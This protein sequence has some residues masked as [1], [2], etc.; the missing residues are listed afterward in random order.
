MALTAG[1]TCYCGTSIPNDSDQVSESKC[2][3]PCWGWGNQTCG[4]DNV[5]GVWADGLSLFT[6]TTAINT[7]TSASQTNNAA[8]TTTSSP[9]V[10]TEANHTVV[11]TATGQTT[12]TGSS[13]SGGGGG[14]SNTAGIAAGV[15][16][17]VV[18]LAAI[19]G[20]SL[21]FIRRQKRRAVEESYR[22]NAAIN[23]FVG[24][25]TKPAAAPMS[26]SRWDGDFM[27]ERRRSNGSIADDEDFSRRILTVTNPDR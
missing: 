3:T 23:G 17:G 2:D 6:G 27:A 8:S 11:V 9:S 24:N 16:V 15:V 10:I 14:G 1:S 7:A 21:F 25:N 20:A 13:G 18:G 19:V 22:R 12:T 26:N 5:Y 4:G